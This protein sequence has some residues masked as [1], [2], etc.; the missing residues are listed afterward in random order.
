M[1]STSGARAAQAGAGAPAGGAAPKVSVPDEDPEVLR[2][3]LEIVADT[4]EA[5]I[6][7]RTGMEDEMKQ[8]REED[9]A[10]VAIDPVEAVQ[11]ADAGIDTE[12]QEESVGVTQPDIES[13]PPLSSLV[14]DPEPGPSAADKTDPPSQ[15]APLDIP[16]QEALSVSLSIPPEAKPPAKDEEPDAGA[17]DPAMH[18]LRMNLLGL[19]KRAPLQT[20]A[21]L[22]AA[23]V[24]EQLRSVVPLL[25]Q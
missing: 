2:H 16:V 17:E 6:R 12:S 14:T 3:V 13:S 9:G 4:I 25:P 1:A 18:A 22:P 24:P 23:L 5:M 15:S 8:K 20:I 10:K 21:P 7:Q 11:P 19:A